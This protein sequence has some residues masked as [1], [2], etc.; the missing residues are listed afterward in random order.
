MYRKLWQ[1]RYCNSFR[2]SPLPLNFDNWP[3][4]RYLQRSTEYILFSFKIKIFSLLDSTSVSL[5]Y[6]FISCVLFQFQWPAIDGGRGG[7]GSKKRHPLSVILNNFKNG[8]AQRC[9]LHPFSGLLQAGFSGLPAAFCT[10]SHQYDTLCENL[11]VI[12]Q[13]LISVFVM[14]L[15]ANRFRSNSAISLE[16]R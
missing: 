10:P 13:F 14:S 9:L 2:L 8:G 7:E 4:A 15:Q 5:T 16:I 6:H 11:K 3:L 12:G 1:Y